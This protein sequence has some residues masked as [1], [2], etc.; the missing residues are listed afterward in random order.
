MTLSDIS[1]RRPVFAWMLM[2]ALIIFGAISFS[3]LGISQLPDVDFPIVSVAVSLPGAAPEVMETE[4]ADTIEDAVMGISGI[5]EVSSSSKQGQTTLTIEFELDKDID[6]ALQ[7]VQTKLAQAQRNLP[8]DIDPPII[9]KTNPEDQPIMW[10]CLSGSVP[11]RELTDYA[12]D[13]V[14]DQFTSAPGVGEVILGGYINPSVRVWVDAKALHSYELTIQDVIR[15]VQTQH[16]E[17]PAGI[18]ENA[19]TES[20]VR[21]IGEARSMNDFEHML[22]P[23]RSNSPLFRS[24][25]L[26]QVAHI[27]D[28]LDDIRRI[29]RF[30]GQMGIG[31][32]IRKQRGTNAVAVSKAVKERLL[33]VQ[34]NLPDNIKMDIV[35]DTTKFIEESTHELNF[36]LLLSAILTSIVCWVFMGSFS[37]AFNIALSIPTSIFGTFIFLYF[38]GF[39]LNTFTLLGLSLVIGIVVDDAIMVLENIVR[40]RELGETKVRAAIIGAREITFAAVAATAAILAIFVPVLFM[41][42]IIGKFFFQFGFTIS[43]AVLL[44]L[45]EALTLAPMRCAQFLDVGHN[46]FM[47]RSMNSI[48]SSLTQGYRK[49]LALCLNYRWLVLIAS[50]IFVAVSFRSVKSLDKEFVP[51]QD[52]SRFMVRIQTPIGSSITHTDALFKDIEAKV[53][54]VPG[55]EKYYAAIGGFSGGEVNAG[56][57]FVTLKDFKKRPIDK[58]TGRPLSQKTIMG[59]VRHTIKATPGITKVVVQDLSLSGFSAQRGFPVEFSLRGPDWDTLGQ[60]SESLKPKMEATGTMTDV[61]SDYVLGMPEYQVVPN[62]ERAAA[63]G[64]NIE[65][66][67]QTIEASIGGVRVGKYTQNGK[68]YDIR[69]RL[70]EEQRRTSDQMK[71]LWVQNNRGELVLMAD[72]VTITQKQTLS[73]ITR[74][75]RERAVGMFANIALGKSQSDALAAVQTLSKDLPRGYSIVL[76]GSAKSY[77]ESFQSLIIALVLGLVVAYMVL[78]TQFNSFIHPVTVLLALPFSLT[79]AF[80]A[81]RLSHQSLNMYSLIGILLL[82]GIV[83]KNSILL[84]DFTNAR[85]KDGLPVNE[86]LMEACPIRLRPI[87]MTS[88]ATIA[89]AVP[90]AIAFGPGSE[91][92][93]PMAVVIIGGVTVSTVLTLFVVPCA[94][95]LFSHIENKRHTT[96]VDEAFESLR[97]QRE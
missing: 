30:Q 15:T 21:V 50:V 41:K 39:T 27:E 65:A 6:V 72:V 20:N 2:S 34:K 32:G 1:I 73:S 12:R 69:V 63:R 45:V 25:T 46:T 68:R 62:R 33:D 3:R 40:Y 14:K 38:S 92:R 70:K 51:S 49:L 88:I 52:Q 19:K 48:M 90:A 31:F 59:M 44:S 23:A 93:V 87:L 82:M 24:I 56:M 16:V 79:G 64:V 8:K 42:G 36:T 67:A 83:K 11:M 7:E 81:L 94:Y 18:I 95:S 13:H 89:A 58:K 35:F 26:G 37:S 86:A 55:V 22:I 84:V 29:S 85:R 4:V 77:K 60:L 5:K 17:L 66:I 54:T 43:V 53:L 71:N 75:N 80:W 97:T 57:L 96:D 76:S 91:T 74:K 9:S 28:G 10:L 78:A 47:A 61:D